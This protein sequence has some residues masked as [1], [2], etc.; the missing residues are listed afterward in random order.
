MLGM[1]KSAQ[2]ESAFPHLRF[3]TEHKK[4][5]MYTAVRVTENSD[6]HRHKK[7]AKLISRSRNASATEGACRP[8]PHGPSPS[9]PQLRAVSC[10]G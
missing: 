2:M 10:L 4:T 9:E 7:G 1:E 6:R 3:G 8:W 5:D